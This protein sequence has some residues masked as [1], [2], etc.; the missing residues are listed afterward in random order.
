[1]TGMSM[2]QMGSGEIDFEQIEK[3]IFCGL[4]SDDKDLKLEQMEDLLDKVSNPKYYMDKMAE[5]LTVAFGT[6]QPQPEGNAKA[7]GK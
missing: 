6:N 1:M 3:I 2:E 5:A 7:A 4:L